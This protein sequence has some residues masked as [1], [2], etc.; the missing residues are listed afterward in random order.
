M[1]SDETRKLTVLV[2]LNDDFEGGKFYIQNGSNRLYPQ[3]TKG[4]AITFPSFMP[5]GVEPVT[6]GIRY[7][8][9]TWMVGPYFK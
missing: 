7:S 4:T 6:K 2:F 1:R 5:H 9:V 8:V 3:Q